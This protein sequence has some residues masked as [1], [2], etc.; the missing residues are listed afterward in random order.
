[1]WTGIGAGVYIFLI[2]VSGSAIV[3]RNEM[4]RALTPEPLVFSGPGERLTQDE[5]R[6]TAARLYPDYTVSQV[7]MSEKNPDLAVEIWLTRADAEHEE[8][9]FH[10]YSGAELGPAVPQS[11]RILDWL[12]DFHDN[13]LTAETGRTVNGVGGL[14]LLLLCGTGVV[15][16]WPGVKNWRKSLSIETRA[17]WKRLNWSLHSAVGF[18]SFLLL[19]MWALSGVYLAFPQP[20][21]AVVD[22]FEPPPAFEDSGEFE[23]RGQQ[24]EDAGPLEERTGDAV[25]RWLTR[26]HF[27]RYFGWPVKVLWTILGLIPPLLFV[28]GALMWWNR[29]VRPGRTRLN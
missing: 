1:M 27:G 2:S 3:F 17:N 5:L 7:W 24:F 29:V 4:H 21:S 12:V 18:W 14:F 15:V 23:F 11:I 25:L 26:L 13:L 6:N 9:L 20:F 16:W 10:P 8:L 19:F 22:Y 28:T